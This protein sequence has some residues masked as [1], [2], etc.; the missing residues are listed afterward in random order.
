[1]AKFRDYTN[2]EIYE[3][4]RIWSYL[5]KKWLK[6]RLSKY[7]Y[8]DILLSNGKPTRFRLNRVVY[9]TFKGEIPEGMYVNHIDENKL[10]NHIS[11]LNLLTPKENSNWGSAPSKHYQAVA[12]YD[13][14]CNLVG[15]Y[16]SIKEASKQLG[17]GESRI[18]NC[19]RG[20]ILKVDGHHFKYLDI[21]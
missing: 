5:T 17:I 15:V 8:Y 16:K 6:P 21:F 10:N 12:Q 3:D 19:C 11:N 9:E 18:S 14:C 20:V 2:Y 7:G 13:K 1:M 4:G